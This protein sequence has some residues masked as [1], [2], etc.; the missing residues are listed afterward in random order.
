MEFNMGGKKINLDDA[1][2]ADYRSA[3]GLLSRSV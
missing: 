1:L 3:V 2:I